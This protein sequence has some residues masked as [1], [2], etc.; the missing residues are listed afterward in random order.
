MNFKK[1]LVNENAALKAILVVNGKFNKGA[2][3]REAWARARRIA[4]NI[5]GAQ[6]CEFFAQALKTT[7]S[8]AKA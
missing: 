4:S 8:I 5:P 2:I 1:A 3:M 7:W 6:A